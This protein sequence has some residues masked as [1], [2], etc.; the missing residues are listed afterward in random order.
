MDTDEGEA[1]KS[2]AYFA[3]KAEEIASIKKDPL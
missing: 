2:A 3:R 1:A